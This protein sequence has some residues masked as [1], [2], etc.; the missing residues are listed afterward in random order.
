MGLLDGFKNL[1]T[2]AV[3]DKAADVLGIQSGNAKSAIKIFAP[4]IIGGLINKGSSQSGAS[5][6]LD[7]F[8]SGGFK[9]ISTGDVL[10]VLGDQNETNSLLE[11]GRSLINTLFGDNQSSAMDFLTEKSSLGKSS[12]SGLLSFIAPMIINKLAGM[13]KDK[14]LDALG[15]SNLL[16]SEKSEIQG[17]IPGFFSL[18]DAG[19]KEVDTSIESTIPSSAS[20]SGS[21]GFLKWLIPVI[22]AAALIW[23]ITKDGCSPAATAEKDEP[24]TEIKPQPSAPSKAKEES[25]AVTTLQK[26]TIDFTDADL[27]DLTINLRGDIIDRTSKV[28]V[29]AGMYTIDDND[30]LLDRRGRLIIPM[31]KLPSSLQERLFSMVEGIKRNRMRT[32]FLGM[33]NDRTGNASLYTLSMIEFNPDNHLI[34]YFSK[35]EVEGLADAL[36][37]QAT[38]KIEVHVYTDDADGRRA[39]Q[40]LS[41]TRANVIRDMLVTLGVNPNQIKAVGKGTEDSEKA[42]SGKVDIVAQQQW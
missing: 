13:V 22:L 1:M 34:S 31:D 15:L 8:D 30:N 36:K 26:S 39:N 41:E 35:S 38:G 28:W 21:K 24:K 40:K 16:Q 42:S 20:Q 32:M 3:V 2:S 4:A 33:L 29:P 5:S 23:F 17:L 10:N 9:D 6:L 7:L 14:G 25:S 18:M 37:E 19:S 27:S 12:T 11:T